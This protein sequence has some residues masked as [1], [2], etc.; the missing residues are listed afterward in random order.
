MISDL[1]RR[2]TACLDTDTL[3]TA[4]ARLAM[5][6]LMVRL[7]RSDDQ[8]SPTERA[9]IDRLLA[10][11]YTLPPAEAATLREQAERAE[12]AAPDTVQF[13]RLIKQSVPYEDRTGVMET[14]WRVATTDGIDAEERGF[15]RLVAELLGVSDQDSGLARQRAERG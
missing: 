13:T 2:L 6:A 4:D 1:F 5:A 12:E 8:Y 10:E 11:H 9:Q 14:L 7:A 3:S 15:L